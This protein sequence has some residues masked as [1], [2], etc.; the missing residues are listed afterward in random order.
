MNID[1][2]DIP[3]D[4][5]G[6]MMAKNH[7]IRQCKLCLAY[8]ECRDTRSI[9]CGD[10]RPKEALVKRFYSAVTNNLSDEARQKILNSR[11]T[12]VGPFWPYNEKKKQEEKNGG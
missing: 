2:F 5:K 4:V 1:N 12:R 9:L 8:F 6:R 11:T 7:S 10:C 3:E